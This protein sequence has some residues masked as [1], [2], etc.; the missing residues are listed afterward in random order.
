VSA[1]NKAMDDAE[2]AYS[3]IVEENALAA[4][5]KAKNRYKFLDEFVRARTPEE[6]AAWDEVSPS[7]STEIQH[8]ET[9]LAKEDYP[10]TQGHADAALTIMDKFLQENPQLAKEFERY[11]SAMAA[12]GPSPSQNEANSPGSN[13]SGDNDAD[14]ANGDDASSPTGD[15]FGVDGSEDGSGD[16]G[17][18]NVA[19]DANGRRIVLPKYYVITV[20]EPVTDCL[21]RISEFDFVYATPLEWRTLYEAIKEHF[22]DPE[23]PD[24]VFP[25]QVL[26]IPSLRGEKREGTHTEGAVYVPLSEQEIPEDTSSTTVEQPAAQPSAEP[27]IN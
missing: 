13:A 9:A 4:L 18:Q 10:A 26:E 6:V 25:G 20:R 21:W 16:A 2:A 12:A 23:N 1:A 14:G 17:G 22:R 11:E 24:L 7:A 27:I 8:S 15:G 19:T 3:K 5:E